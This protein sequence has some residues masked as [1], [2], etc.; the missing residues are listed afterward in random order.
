MK[1]CLSQSCTMTTPFADDLAAYAGGGCQAIE[2]WLTKLE[3]HLQSHSVD[4]TQKL[5]EQHALTLAA[6]AMQG[7]LLLSLGEK[8]SAHWDHFKRRLD[9]CQRFA[10]PTLVV[11]ADPV[12]VVESHTL[13]HA[14]AS[15]AEA[16]QWAAGFGVRLAFKFQGIGAVCTTLETAVRIVEEIGDPNLGVCLDAFHFFKGP[17]KVEDLSL[18][19]VSNLVHVQVCDVA[20]VPRELMTDSDRVF[21][22]EGDFSRQ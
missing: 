9:L 14:I 21:P 17:S 11:A 22:G 12:T 16:A 10:I 6:A 18:L 3:T 1:L 20:G 7:G 8:R 19:T 13:G 5:I 2:A 4:E 15:L